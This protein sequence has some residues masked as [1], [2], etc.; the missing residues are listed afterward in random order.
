MFDSLTFETY[1][2]LF[3]IGVYFCAEAWMQ[4]PDKDS[5]KLWIKG[6]LTRKK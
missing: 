4:H 6:R 1:A 2:P 5:V 3:A